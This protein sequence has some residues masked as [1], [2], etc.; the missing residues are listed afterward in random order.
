[1]PPPGL[2]AETPTH[3]SQILSVAEKSAIILHDFQD[4]SPEATG[5]AAV[6]QRRKL[7]WRGRGLMPENPV[8]Q[9]SDFC[10]L[11]SRLPR[12]GRCPVGELGG[13]Q[14]PMFT[15]PTFRP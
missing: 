3:A 10:T 5:G 6:E 9:I 12:R 4:A 13:V 14:I 15:V 8:Q 7:T 11:S 2:W 1:R